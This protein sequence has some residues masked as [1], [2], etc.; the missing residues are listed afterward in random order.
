VYYIPFDPTTSQHILAYYHI[1]T[2]KN[3]YLTDPNTLPFTI[4]N[5]DWAVAPDGRAIAFVQAGD[6][7]VWLLENRAE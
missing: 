5:G 6:K 1:P 7:N 2:R 4:A 3:R